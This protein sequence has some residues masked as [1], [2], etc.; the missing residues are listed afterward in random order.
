MRNVPFMPTVCPNVWNS[1]RQPSTTSLR[2]ESFAS[3]TLTVAF[4]TR[5]RC[6][7]SAPF[8]SPVV[9]LV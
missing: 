7:S 8:G 5:L 2:V 6:V 3:K 1:G 9:P 4:I